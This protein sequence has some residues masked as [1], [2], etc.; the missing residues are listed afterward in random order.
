MLGRHQVKTMTTI[1]RLPS[2][3][4]LHGAST[5]QDHSSTTWGVQP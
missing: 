2:P 4:L 1:E 3:D 5:L